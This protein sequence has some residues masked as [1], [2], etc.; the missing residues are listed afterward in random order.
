MYTYMASS[1]DYIYTLDCYAVKKGKSSMFLGETR[2]SYAPIIIAL[3]QAHS[4]LRT[5]KLRMV[6]TGERER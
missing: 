5:L 6:G 2:N 4:K 1:M 3:F